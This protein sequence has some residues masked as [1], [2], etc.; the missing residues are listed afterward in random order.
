MCCILRCCRAAFTALL[1][2][3]WTG[4]PVS[5][6]QDAGTHVDIDGIAR[7]WTIHDLLARGEEPTAE[8]W[9]ALFAT[10]GY[11]LLEAR[12]GRRRALQQAFRHAY[13]RDA[14]GG[15]APTG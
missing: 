4:L 9:D 5:A 2:T 6:A 8:T 14:A 10:S 7:F 15:P 1:L 11:A 13:R 12:E 3:L